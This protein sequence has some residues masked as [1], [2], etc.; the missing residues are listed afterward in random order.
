MGFGI[1]AIAG[2]G[3]LLTAPPAPTETERPE[4]SGRPADTVLWNARIYTGDDDQ[5]LAS[6]VAIREEKI[7]YVGERDDSSWQ[8]LVGPNTNVVDVEGRTIIPGSVDSHTHP[9]LVAVS[10]WHISLPRTN[11]L[12]TILNFVRQY[13]AD[14]PASDVPFI[15]AEYYPSDMDWGPDGPT[16][17]AI[18]AAV[19]DRPVLLQ[20]FSD[21]AST[22]NSKM[23][24]L[25]GVDEDTSIQIDPNDPGPQFVRGANGVSPTGLVRERAWTYF[26]DTMYD[27]IG[28]RP[29]EDVTPALLEPFTSFLSAKGVVALL[30]AATSRTAISSAATLD[31]QGKLNLY[32]H[33]AKVFSS[34]ANLD[35]S[36]AEVRA[37][38]EEFGGPHVKVAAMKLF[39][40]GTNEF[41]TGAVL[42]PLIMEGGDHG[43]LR[44]SED[45][46]TSA[47]QTL[48]AEDID[49]HIHVVGDRGFRVALNAVERAQENRG[50]IWRIQVTL[51]H[52]ELVDPS[53]MPRVAEL[54]VLLNWTPHW[55]G[56]YFGV[57]AADH[58]GWERF[59]RMYQFNPVI[60]SGGT[61]TYGSDV[62]TQ[63]E[64]NRADP[65]FGM[66]V[67]HTRIDPQYPMQPGPG[68]VEGTQIREPLSARLSLPDLVQGYTLNGAI[69]LRLEAEMGSIEVGKVA[70]LSVLDADLFEVP[71]D[72]IQD[73]EPDAVLFAGRLIHGTLT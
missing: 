54:G 11:D 38:Q 8:E 51:S 52:D 12:N 69:Q 60:T 3:G 29:P 42:D 40:D 48:D 23:L 55:S 17:A 61:V 20:D 18:D 32:Y 68:T 27:A 41:G 62:V 56:G 9:G 6:V 21:H 14:H 33:G 58:L 5:S 49:M 1:A 44:M 36:I 28:W 59:N 15:Y 57:A 50:G 4:K 43:L 72:K 47:M 53:D 73:V 35:A 70:N 39:L 30:D 19:S 13:A 66:Q 22:V 26:T 46:L 67:A 65:F 16:A 2:V 63:Y 45:D 24:E 7:V 64:A 34:L 25:M 31:A 37:W 71:D 10:S